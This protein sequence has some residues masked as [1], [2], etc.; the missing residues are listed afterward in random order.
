MSNNTDENDGVKVPLLPLSGAELMLWRSCRLQLHSIEHGDLTGALSA[1][2]TLQLTSTAQLS[3]TGYR[4]HDIGREDVVGE[5]PKA[6]ATGVP[7]GPHLAGKIIAD[8]NETTATW[9]PFS[10]HR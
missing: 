10:F 3:L 2:F 5:I 7:L 4:F 9:C 1:S 6:F 8:S